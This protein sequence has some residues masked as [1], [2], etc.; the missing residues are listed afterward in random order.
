V[1]A[2]EHELMARTGYA[3]LEPASNAHRTTNRAQNTVPMQVARVSGRR[4]GR[5]MA[6]AVP[7]GMQE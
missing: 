1:A 6:P 5:L 2:N 7:K 4:R 3:L